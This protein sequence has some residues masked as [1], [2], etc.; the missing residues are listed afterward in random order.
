MNHYHLSSNTELTIC[1]SGD[2]SREFPAMI[3]AAQEPIVA[4][5]TVTRTVG[6]HCTMVVVEHPETETTV[7]RSRECD[8]S[9][10]FTALRDF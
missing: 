3:A 8:D 7:L 1:T 5:T 4:G 2:A 10:C 9:S 6:E